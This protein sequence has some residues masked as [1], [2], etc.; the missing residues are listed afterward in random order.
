MPRLRPR[1]PEPGLRLTGATAFLQV[2]GLDVDARMTGF[3]FG[4][5]SVGMSGLNVEA[6]P[7]GPALGLV[8]VG[9]PGLD[10]PL[11][12]VGQP[13]LGGQLLFD[14]LAVQRARVVVGSSQSP[15]ATVTMPG[16]DV[17]AAIE[18][19]GGQ[20]RLAPD[21]SLDWVR[22]KK[23][24]S[25]GVVQVGSPVSNGVEMSGGPGGAETSGS[26]ALVSKNKSGPGW[27]ASFTLKKTDGYTPPSGDGHA[28]LDFY[29]GAVGD[30]TSGFPVDIAQ[31]A[32]TTE[33]YAGT[34]A[35]HVTG[36]RLRFFDQGPGNVRNPT[37]FVKV[38]THGNGGLIGLNR[39]GSDLISAPGIDA[40]EKNFQINLPRDNV[41]YDFRGVTF[42]NHLDANSP[43]SCIRVNDDKGDHNNIVFFGGR[44][45]GGGTG[46][47]GEDDPLKVTWGMR[48]HGRKFAQGY[49]NEIFN[50]DH[51]AW[52]GDV[53]FW[54][55]INKTHRVECAFYYNQQDGVNPRRGSGPL[56]K[57][58]VSS[59]YYRYRNDDD[60][61]D[62]GATPIEYYDC[63]FEDIH[64][65]LSASAG[66]G[67]IVARNCLIHV[68]RLP[69]DCDGVS[70]EGSPHAGTKFR[71]PYP[72]QDTSLG[73]TTVRGWVAGRI[74]KFN[75]VRQ[76]DIQDCVIRLDGPQPFGTDF[77]PNGRYSNVVFVY[78]GPDH[79]PPDSSQN[80]PSSVDMY[81]GDSG[82]KSRDAGLAIWNDAVDEWLVG[83]GC[84]T[85]DHTA[86][87]GVMRNIPFTNSSKA[88]M[89]APASAPSE[90][91]LPTLTLTTADG[92]ETAIAPDGSPAPLNQLRN[93]PYDY[94]L[95]LSTAATPV[96]TLTQHDASTGITRALTW[97]SA[98]LRTL[99]SPSQGSFVWDCPPGR[100]V[101]ITA[102][103]ITPPVVPHPAATLVLR[104]FD[105][106]RATVETGG[107]P[108][109]GWPNGYTNRRTFVVPPQD[110]VAASTLAD[111]IITL[112]TAKLPAQDWTWL[113]TEFLSP[114]PV[115]GFPLDLRLT[116]VA[117]PEAQID[118]RVVLFKSSP[119]PRLVLQMRVPAPGLVVGPAGTTFP[120]RLFSGKA[121]MT[122]TEEHIPAVFGG[123]LWAR[124]F[125]DG[126]DLSGRNR[127]LTSIAGV[128]AGTIDGLP[129]GVFTAAVDAGGDGTSYARVTDPTAY[130]AQLPALTI[131]IRLRIA[132]AAPA[133]GASLWRAGGLPGS[134]Q[135]AA[136]ASV[137][138]ITQAFQAGW[139]PA[140]PIT[141]SQAGKDNEVLGPSGSALAGDL[142]LWH[143]VVQSNRNVRIFKDATE[144]VTTYVGTGNPLATGEMW[145][146][147]TDVEGFG[148]GTGTQK[149]A[150]AGTY[151]MALAWPKALGSSW[152]P[153]SAR[154]QVTPRELVGIGVAD[155]AD[156]ATTSPVAV[157]VR[158]TI[159]GQTDIDVA[160][161]AFDDE[162]PRTV[163]LV[164]VT[165]IDT[166]CSFLVAGGKVRAKPASGTNLVPSVAD[167]V[168]GK[169]AKRSTARLSLTVSDDV[170]MSGE[171]QAAAIPAPISG[172]VFVVT[173]AAQIATQV[174]RY[175]A[176]DQIVMAAGTY[177]G[178]VT[179]ARSGTSAKP[180]VFRAGTY[181]ATTN[182]I[183]DA[184]GSVTL[185]GAVSITGTDVI[186]RGVKCPQ[187]IAASAAAARSRVNRCVM[188]GASA[189]CDMDGVDQSFDWN[190]VSGCNG[191][192]L[193]HKIA[194]GC[195]RPF[196]YRN[197]FH[198]Q[199][200]ATLP[201]NR[202]M[203]TIGYGKGDA[204]IVCGAVYLENLYSGTHASHDTLEIKCSGNILR[205]NTLRDAVDSQAQA[206]AHGPF[207]I[208]NR[209]GDDN[210]YDRNWLEDGRISC[211]GR[212]NIAVRNKTSGLK[213]PEA[214]ASSG[215]CTTTQWLAGTGS[216]PIAE[217]MR[218]IYHDG[219]ANCG[220]NVSSGT[221]A[222]TGT[223]IEWGG[224]NNVAKPTITATPP[225]T[226][227]D[228]TQVANST[229]PDP[230]APVR[231]AYTQVGPA[232]VV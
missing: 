213:S 93:F 47:A 193:G 130:L 153:I 211:R 129:G 90:T 127:H 19:L 218:I 70:D 89:L 50:C 212:R 146:Y 45:I 168:V 170:V 207:D 158:R 121:G 61:Q 177:A 139:N 131:E 216:Y 203:T 11:A 98:L 25:A 134:A 183:T 49:P 164:S 178:T 56:G 214:F 9:A 94:T 200:P 225:A 148:A 4:L 210:L 154:S 187:G 186:L 55:N 92:T 152:V 156:D 135:P 78:T 57:V 82:P 12:T 73:K 66:N 231:L 91:V 109:G 33:P 112:D 113:A 115:T 128:T 142:S 40:T 63:F 201:N 195:R 136:R 192:L 31:W 162:S 176:G 87:P 114:N 166:N 221:I 220:E 43:H 122:A 105:V 117:T 173:T 26:V 175:V 205:G 96:L 217:N 137:F 10:V 36:A 22:I 80:I 145:P 110:D 68:G 95:A 2:P 59:C 52:D 64:A 123:T 167:F 199:D 143:F 230:G 58:I 124:T 7:D 204:L 42:H 46:K 71:G 155:L 194:A 16:L 83:H 172:Q 101:E 14:R 229:Y 190:E 151:G 3:D 125:P 99:A 65:W 62:N 232:G 116:T 21:Y 38:A 86:G 106:P 119:P 18:P 97:T 174:G 160:A 34:L 84:T 37:G 24:A 30:G 228:I 157:P 180:V 209:S 32:R 141:H 138:Q 67:D 206:T 223:K 159:V 179:F 79:F 107:P 108:P 132:S 198:D 202:T 161:L 1:G 197:W 120:F 88:A 17:D 81:Q 185:S 222:P 103:G 184:I 28:Y 39:T 23:L 69:Y 171:G 13:G 44:F 76:I 75:T 54:G 111:F 48:K 5:V 169:G 8:S 53:I 196:V 215:D 189:I 224:P 35:A 29:F 191:H 133:A 140:D 41:T 6:L 226:L 147:A 181:N 126:R 104:G 77:W 188:S 102:E 144:L 51:G 85:S 150:L 182:T 149:A 74:L 118:H 27:S 72:N 60:E 219:T 15:M 165:P 100:V 227:A 208:T 163:A 20:F